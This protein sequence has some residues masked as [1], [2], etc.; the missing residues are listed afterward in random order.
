MSPAAP[1]AVPASPASSKRSRSK[2]S[3][4]SAATSSLLATPALNTPFLTPSASAPSLLIPSPA[5]LP[6]IEPSASDPTP[7]PAFLRL[8]RPEL[9][10]KFV[11]LEWEHR[12]RG[13]QGNGQSE[14]EPSPWSRCTWEDALPRNRYANVDPYQ[15]NRVKLDVPEGQNDYINASP[16]ELK[17]SQSGAVLK[18]IATQ[19]PKNDTYS[20][21]WRMVWNETSDP[22][23]IVMLTQTH[24]SGRE[25]CYPYYPPSPAHPDLKLNAEDEYEDGFIHD[26]RLASLEEHAESRAQFRDLEM[27]DAEGSKTKKISHLLFGAW[28]DFSVP[29][30]PDREALLRLI[31]ISREKTGDLANPRIVHCSAGVGRSGT[32]IALD[33]LLQE[34]SEGSLDNVPDEKDPV[35]SVV[36]KLREQRMMMVQGEAQLA[37]I[38]DVLRQ[39]WR[40]RWIQQHPEEAE[41]LGISVISGGDG[42]EEPSLKRQKSMASSEGTSVSIMNNGSDSQER[43]QLEAELMDAEHDFEKG[44]T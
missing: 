5:E 37:F 16:I 43:A 12:R 1:L 29:E 36:E 20:H 23:V 44:K 2:D 38:Y 3:T 35:I 15:A 8:S 32:F 42:S 18:Y 33:W 41:A 11:D 4:R 30:G 17:S 22:A 27:S 21:F 13:L 34:L 6:M 19:G 40:E 7:H 14:A 28:P 31:D 9:H 24:E 39:R 25:K 10:Q 26:L